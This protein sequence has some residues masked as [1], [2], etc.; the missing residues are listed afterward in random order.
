MHTQQLTWQQVI[1]QA[2]TDPGEFIQCLGLDASLIDAA[3]QAATLFPLRVPRGFVARMRHGDVNDPLLRQVLPLGIETEFT[4]GFSN[5]PLGES[6]VN[7]LPGLLHKYHGRALM[8]M[9]SACGVNCRYCF[10]RAFPYDQNNPGSEGFENILRYIDDDKTLSEIIFSGGDPLMVSDTLLA[11]RVKQLEKIPHLKRVR[12]HTRM[13][14]IVP[15]RI[16]SELLTWIQA[17][18]FQIILVV[19]ANHPNEVNDEVKHAM[20]KLRGLNVTV[21]NQSVLLKGVN[22][23]A[24]TLIALSEK[25]FDAHIL[26]Y[27]LHAL[28]RVQGAAHFDLPRATAI[29]LHKSMQ[30][31]LPGFLVP[32]LVEEKAGAKSKWMVQC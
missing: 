4:P 31:K 15:E 25:L 3:Q 14:I 5:D 9:T 17:S 16:C 2:I 28:D 24:E 27:Y 13:P 21:L 8:T 26:P 12:I 1:Q 7:P 11:T 10:R 30:E 22:D 6:D 19:H 18:R 23:N 32:K 29:S 20:Q